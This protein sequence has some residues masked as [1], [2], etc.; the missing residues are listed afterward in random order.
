[1]SSEQ[2]FTGGLHLEIREREERETERERGEIN[3]EKV[4]EGEYGENSIY[5]CIKIEK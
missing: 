1:V 2:R 3:Q 4:K 5:S